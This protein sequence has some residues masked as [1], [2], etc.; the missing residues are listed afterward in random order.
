MKDSKKWIESCDLKVW[1][2][3]MIKQEQITKFPTNILIDRNRK[4]LAYNLYD[5]ALY[6]E[7]KQRIDADDAEK[8]NKKK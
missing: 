1:G 8:K 4:K 2:M 5:D 6:K 7:V 3:P